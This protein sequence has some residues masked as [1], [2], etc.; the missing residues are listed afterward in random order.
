MSGCYYLRA[1]EDARYVAFVDMSGG[2]SD[3]AAL[4]IAHYDDGYRRAVLNVIVTQTGRPPFNP[5]D[6]VHKF[7]TLLSQYRVSRVVGDRYA[8]ETFVQDFLDHGV[9]Y[10]LATHTKSELYEALEPR[11]N[12]WEVELLDSQKFIEQLLGL[13][14]RGTKI[15]HQAGDHDDLANAAA[16]ALHLAIPAVEFTSEHFVLVPHESPYDSSTSPYQAQ[17]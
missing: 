4:A 9:S 5:R 12:A 15:D 14:V 3:D 13:V 1:Q 17:S 8:G 11:I 6:A 10:Q 2:S 7:A 16:G